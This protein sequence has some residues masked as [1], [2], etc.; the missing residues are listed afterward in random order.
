MQQKNIMLKKTK[1]TNKTPNHIFTIYILQ[2]CHNTYV[3]CHY[4]YNFNFK[5]KVKKMNFQLVT[6][7]MKPRLEKNNICL[8][9]SLLFCKVFIYDSEF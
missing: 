5:K 4:T 9:I 2:T 7:C 3:S 8:F 1:Q 6:S